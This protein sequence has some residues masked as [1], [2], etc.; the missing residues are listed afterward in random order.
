MQNNVQFA[1]FLCNLFGD[2]D[3]KEKKKNFKYINVMKEEFDYVDGFRNGLARARKGNKW[4]IIDEEFDTIYPF[5]FDSI[6]KFYGKPFN[7]IV[8]EKDGELFKIE[9]DNPTE[10]V[11]YYNDTQSDYNDYGNPWEDEPGWGSYEEYGG[12]NGYDDFTIDAAFE[13]DPDAV[14]NID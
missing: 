10:I 13:G 3:T 2:D 7:R 1:L 14:W 4:G 6:W 5:E 12:P 11:P 9:F 8:L